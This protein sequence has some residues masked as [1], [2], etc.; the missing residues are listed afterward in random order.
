MGPLIDAKSRDKVDEL[1]T[2]A[3]SSGTVAATG[4]GPVTG[5]GYFSQPTIFTVVGDPKR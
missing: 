2:D 5:P 3:V 1:V 4:G